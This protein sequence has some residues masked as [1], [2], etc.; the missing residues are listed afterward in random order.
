MKTTLSKI[1]F[2][3][4]F[5]LLLLACIIFREKSYIFECKLLLEVEKMRGDHALEVC[6]FSMKILKSVIK[7][8]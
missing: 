2:I 4:L 8:Y 1:P 7:K 5:V 3:D 6:L